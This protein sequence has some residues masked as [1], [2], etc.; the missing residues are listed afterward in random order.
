MARS[1]LATTA[2]A[3]IVTK[4]YWRRFLA[5][6]VAP[7]NLEDP[8]RKHPRYPFHAEGT[9]EVRHMARTSRCH[10]TILEVALDGFTGR[11]DV[12]L[13]PEA[14]VRFEFAPEGR[15]I[16]LEGRVMHSTQTVGGFKTG[17]QLDFPPAPEPHR[18]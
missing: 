17:I 9:L 16:A 11:T 15:P 8:R 2:T 10:I 6:T 5:R 13:P 18:G 4:D 3:A 7:A 12:V 14:K 1:D